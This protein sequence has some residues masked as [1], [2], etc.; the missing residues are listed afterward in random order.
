MNLEKNAIN[1]RIAT[2]MKDNESINSKL[3]Y[4]QIKIHLTSERKKG[5]ER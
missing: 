3:K 4:K 1:D 5:I 2:L